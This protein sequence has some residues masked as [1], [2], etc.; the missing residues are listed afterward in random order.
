M[1]N[2]NENATV[3]ILPKILE[4]NWLQ[5]KI[6]KSAT[7]AITSDLTIRAWSIK[8]RRKKLITQFGEKSRDERFEPN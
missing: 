3:S 2:N 8:Y 4:L 1:L 7:V 6:L 5:P